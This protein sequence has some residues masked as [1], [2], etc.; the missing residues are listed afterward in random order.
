MPG[1]ESGFRPHL[2]LETIS[3][4][5][6]VGI[7]PII[8][9]SIEHGNDLVFGYRIGDLA[10]LTDCNRIPVATIAALAGIETLVIDALRFSPHATHFTIPE[11][12][13][14]AQDLG[15][16]RTILTHL[17]HDVDARQ[18]GDSLPSG[19]ELAYDGQVIPFTLT[20]P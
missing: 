16:K 5:F 15:I 14:F 19:V 17:S 9:L 2:R 7:V 6:M 11:A 4:P 10:Y 3:G 12:I 18:H 8:P 13:A 20:P 1:E